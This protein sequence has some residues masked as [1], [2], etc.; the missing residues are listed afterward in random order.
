MF[1][2]N[3]EFK[4][5]L[6]S[7]VIHAIILLALLAFKINPEVDLKEYVTIGFGTIAK[8][9]SSGSMEKSKI[10]KVNKKKKDEVVVPKTKNIDKTNEVVAVKSL[11]K[12]VQKKK[13]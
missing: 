3:T 5:T 9:N 8:S 11:H 2:K 4:S 6:I 13:K 10:T 7:I 12:S 1:W